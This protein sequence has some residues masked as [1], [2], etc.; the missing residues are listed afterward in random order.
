MSYYTIIINIVQWNYLNECQVK[1]VNNI[2]IM[3][4]AESE[5][6]KKTNLFNKKAIVVIPIVLA[7]VLGSV[8]TLG[9]VGKVDNQTDEDISQPQQLSID[10]LKKLIDDET[11]LK[12]IDIHEN[13]EKYKDKM[14]TIEAQ[15]FQF[16][17]GY[18]VG[19]EYFFEGG[20]SLLFDIPADFSNVE[21]PKDIKNLDRVKVTGKIRIVEETHDEHSHPIPMIYV[22]SVE[23]LK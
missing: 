5:N 21:L 3:N 1:Y 13:P 14:E 16:E 22:T 7:L 17:D 18:S 4:I 19:I 6:M 20:D 10:E 12:I 11:V 9:L 23:I 2:L 15:F 8:G